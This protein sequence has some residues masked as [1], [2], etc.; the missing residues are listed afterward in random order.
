MIAERQA[1]R[2]AVALLLPPIVWSIYFAIVYGAT[3]V[4]C[5]LAPGARQMQLTGFLVAMALLTLATMLPIIWT[6]AAALRR[7]RRGDGSFVPRLAALMAASF[8]VAT[9]FLAVP[10]IWLEQPCS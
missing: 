1:S 8:L 3:A 4:M 5:E 6:G 10:I 9:V 7:L 2:P